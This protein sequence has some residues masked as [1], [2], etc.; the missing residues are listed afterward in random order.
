MF[1]YFLGRYPK[2]LLYTDDSKGRNRF[3]PVGDLGGSGTA[4]TASYGSALFNN[5]NENPLSPD[6]SQYVEI[7]L[8]SGSSGYLNLDLTQLPASPTLDPNR[9]EAHIRLVAAII[10]GD[11][12]NI[13]IS[14]NNYY[15]ENTPISG[16]LTTYDLLLPSYSSGGSFA[17]K[18]SMGINPTGSSSQLRI[19]AIDMIFLSKTNSIAGFF[20]PF[21]G[22]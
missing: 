12:M 7:S 14:A 15:N 5:I 6:T 19:Y 2:T 21:C 17:N 13:Q 10:S 1:Q 3:K 11:P 20:L 16:G 22:P 18:L 8:T 4:C 9:H